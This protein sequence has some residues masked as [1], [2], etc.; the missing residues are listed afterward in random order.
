MVTMNTSPLSPKYTRIFNTNESGKYRR[1][2]T[3]QKND[4]SIL[5]HQ[6]KTRKKKFQVMEQQRPRITRKSKITHR[7]HENIESIAVTIENLNLQFKTGKKKKFQ[8]VEQQGPRTTRNFKI[9]LKDQK[10]SELFTGT[11]ENLNFQFKTVLPKSI[12]RYRNL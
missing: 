10:N 9:T 12:F 2:V 3:D 8:V 11:I 7:D 1:K 4:P 6:R 5:F